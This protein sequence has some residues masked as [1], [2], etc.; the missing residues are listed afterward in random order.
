MSAEVLIQPSRDDVSALILA[1]GSGA[2]MADRPKAFLAAGGKT[3]VERAVVQV[4]PFATEVIVG[5]REKDL[6][7]SVT[8]SSN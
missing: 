2:R 3:L 1:A 6:D 5:V 8:G 7:A 4:R